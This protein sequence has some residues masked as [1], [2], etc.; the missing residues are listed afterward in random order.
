MS[1]SAELYPDIPSGLHSE[2]VLD[3]QVGNN[4]ALFSVT[5]LRIGAR[6]ALP[7]VAVRNRDDMSSNV[8]RG[9]RAFFNVELLDLIGCGRLPVERETGLQRYPDFTRVAVFDANLMFDRPVLRANFPLPREAQMRRGGIV[10][11]ADDMLIRMALGNV[12]VPLDPA[13]VS[14]NFYLG[15]G[16]LIHTV[17]QDLS[18]ILKSRQLWRMQAGLKTQFCFSRF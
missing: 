15:D 6:S 9:V 3:Q 7:F 4:L 2:R 11:K 18:A 10:Y 1:A 13:H 17:S 16:S 5:W 8:G 14:P 12:Q